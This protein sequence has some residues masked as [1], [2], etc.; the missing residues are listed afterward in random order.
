MKIS[1]REIKAETGI[2]FGTSGVRAKVEELTDKLCYSYSKGF[3]QYLFNEGLIG[4]GESVAVAGDYR[5]STPRIMEAVARAIVDM[6]LSVVNCGFVPSPAI[7]YFGNKRGMASIMVTGSHIPDDRNGIKYNLKDREIL[8]SDEAGIT[9][10]E[11][12]LDESLFN[13]DGSF[14]DDKKVLPEAISEARD[15]YKE[16]YLNFFSEGFLRGKK[17]GLYQHSAV[18]REV[19]AEILE[20]LGTEV[21]CIDKSEVFVP[22][23]T[24]VI[25][26]EL[27]AKGRE[28]SKEYGLDCI[29]STDGDS[30]R[31]LLA[32]E[33]G[34][35]LRAD[36]LGILVGKYLGIEGIVAPVSCNTA[37]EKSGYFKK[38]VRT[39]IG[40]P[41]V[42]EAMM[43]MEKEGLLVGGYE[44]N[45]GFLLQSKIVENSRELGALKTRDALIV[46]LAIIGLAKSENKKIGELAEELPRR[47]TQS[48]S[49]KGFPTEKALEL[50]SRLK[51]GSFEEQKEKIEEITMMKFGEVVKVNT[52]DGL[53]VTFEGDRVVHFRPSMNA[54]EF[55]NYVEAESSE[56][57]N[58]LSIKANEMIRSWM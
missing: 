54:P 22:V 5:K 40:S 4:K 45:G 1:L 6:E 58:E 47:F 38:V 8:K 48:D 14:T 56:E 18:G 17:I 16:R 20:K 10:A 35:W 7:S 50:I 55:R 11:I 27:R 46:P 3:L 39:K 13:V 29:I 53:R 19:I 30:D 37:L 25:S 21:V 49:V 23:D 43:E 32:D 57:A 52:I 28:W 44:A 2:G 26:E 31:P 15:I 24:E 33:R 34:E 12:E 36:T 41:Y 9:G 51:E 42:L